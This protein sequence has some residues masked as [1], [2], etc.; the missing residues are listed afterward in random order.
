MTIGYSCTKLCL[1]ACLS[2]MTSIPAWADLQSGKAEKELQHTEEAWHARCSET[3]TPETLR[4]DHARA[5]YELTLDYSLID[6]QT[7]STNRLA[8]QYLTKAKFHVASSETAQI[9]SQDFA[10]ANTEFKLAK[11]YLE[12]AKATVEKANTSQ[13]E[14]LE[15]VLP[16]FDAL[17][18]KNWSNCWAEQERRA[19]EAIKSDIENLLKIL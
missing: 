17:L 2:A 1:I 11:A 3:A 16:Q 12:K 19:F 4:W 18:Q 14:A 10:L 7:H 9:G 6:L 15:K 8:K 13:I 5:V